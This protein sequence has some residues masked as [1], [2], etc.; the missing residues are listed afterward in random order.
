MNPRERVFRYYQDYKRAVENLGIAVRTA[1]DDLGIDGTIKR[2]ELCYELAW[3][4]IKEVLAD[5]GIICKNPRDCFKE[6]FNNKLIDDQERWLDMIKDR[7]LLVHTYDASIS[8][9]VFQHIEEKYL[10]AFLYLNNQV[11]KELNE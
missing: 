1:K 5:R 3:K 8:R 11:K 10:P 6:A 4:L 2:F 9:E 7:N